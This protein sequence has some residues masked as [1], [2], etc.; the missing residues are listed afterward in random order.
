[1]T[2]WIC[3]ECGK[4]FHRMRCH[5]RGQKH[6]CNQKCRG[7]YYKTHSTH[8]KGNFSMQKKLN[9]LAKM[10]KQLMEAKI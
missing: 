3:D 5:T 8:T 10:R 2:K 9:D 1:M 4:T 7:D 6:F